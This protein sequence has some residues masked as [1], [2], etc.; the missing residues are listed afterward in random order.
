ML[1]VGTFLFVLVTFL[2]PL[3]EC[4]DRWDAPG[5]A[6]DTEFGLFTLIFA[7]CLVLLV[8]MLM[9]AR[10]MLVKFASIRSFFFDHCWLPIMSALCTS[11]LIPPR[12]NSPLRI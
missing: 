10:S 7:L 5:L 6:N 11:L 8:C 3:M 1:Q 4:F 9:A 2:A 12:I